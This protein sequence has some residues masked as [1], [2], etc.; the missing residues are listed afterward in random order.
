ML[1]DPSTSITEVCY[2]LGFTDLSYFDRQFKKAEGITP[3][4]YKH[5]NRPV[6]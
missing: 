3:R 1:N 6:S 5:L 2:D 4:Q